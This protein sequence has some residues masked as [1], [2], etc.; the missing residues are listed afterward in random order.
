MTQIRTLALATTLALASPMLF[1]QT[2]TTTLTP[3]KD[4]ISDV[5]IQADHQSYEALQARIKGLSDRG[6]PIR[7]YHLSKAQCWLDVSLHEYTRNDRSA[8]P[9]AALSESEKLIQGMERG[10]G[11]LPMDTALVNDAA[12]VRPDLWE[13]AAAL[14]GHAGFRCAQQK[15]ACGEVELVHAGNE[16]NQQQWRH[17]KPYVQ[18]AEDL[19]GEA[20]ELAEACAA[21]VAPAV[22]AATPAQGGPAAAPGAAVAAAPVMAAV[23]AKPDLQLA[24]GVL[25]SFD[26]HDT[27]GMKA[28]SAVQLQDMVARVQRDK[29]VVRSVQLS[30]HADR[31]KHGAQPDYNLRLSEKRV[32]TVKAALV[33]LGIDGALIQT[34]ARGDAMQIARCEKAFKRPADLQECLLPNRRVEVLIDAKRP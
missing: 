18:T 24:S 27:A 3:P 8:F 32:A 4:R 11:A 9:Q 25:F 22:T 28:F 34:T 15:L 12:R 17:A 19:L 21:P 6:R 5:A 30:G 20:R 16:Q 31:L 10:A 23:A 14:K 1:A 29:L 13:R 7:D 2:A 33:K 26:R